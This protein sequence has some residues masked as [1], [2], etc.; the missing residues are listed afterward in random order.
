VTASTRRAPEKACKPGTVLRFANPCHLT[1]LWRRDYRPRSSARKRAL[2][3][4]WSH[5]GRKACRP[6]DRAL[7]CN[8]EGPTMNVATDMAGGLQPADSHLVEQWRQH[9][10]AQGWSRSSASRAAARP[11]AFARVTTHGLLPLSTA[12]SPVSRRARLGTGARKEPMVRPVASRTWTRSAWSCFG[13]GRGPPRPW[14]PAGD[15]LGGTL[16]S[17]RAHGCVPSPP[18]YAFRRRGVGMRCV[19]CARHKSVPL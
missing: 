18:G 2:A 17:L 16:P 11:R 1:A 10:V 5:F 9:L 12:R 4:R 7:S 14:C 8:L 6:P 15:G 3:E 19:V 13:R